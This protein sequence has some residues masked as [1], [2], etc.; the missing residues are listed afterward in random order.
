MLHA[1]QFAQRPIR[2]RI[3][4]FVIAP[5][6]AAGQ[7]AAARL[8]KGAHGR[9]LGVAQG[10]HVRE[11]QRGQLP[12]CN[13]RRQV[14]GVHR[15]VG[16]ARREQR[17]R[18]ALPGMVYFQAGLV[19]PIK[20]GVALA[21][22]HPQ[23]GHRLPVEEVFFV[24]GVPLPQAFGRA[25][26][27]AVLVRRANMMPPRLDATSQPRHHPQARL[28]LRLARQPERRAAA[29]LVHGHAFGDQLI[30]TQQVVQQMTGLAVGLKAARRRHRCAH[31]PRL[32]VEQQ[33]FGA[34]RDAAQIAE[35]GPLPNRV[36]AHH[37]DPQAVGPAGLTHGAVVNLPD[38]QTAGVTPL[39]PLAVCRVVPVFTPW[40][41]AARGSQKAA[42]RVRVIVDRLAAQAAEAVIGK[43]IGPVAP[44]DLAQH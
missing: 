15:L 22:H 36:A 6:L 1:Q 11:G 16:D 24:L 13:R 44:R 41:R 18:Q 5:A 31:R 29:V 23:R 38:L 9:K 25:I 35:T 7:Q 10:P 30:P 14:V 20:V 4:P 28:R 39:D 37:A 19:S 12:A 43:A 26:L 32:R 3:A 17:A 33:H 42:R 40:Q 8:H 2:A 21:P 27:A 34:L